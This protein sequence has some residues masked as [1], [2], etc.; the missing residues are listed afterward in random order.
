MCDHD[1]ENEEYELKEHDCGLESHIEDIHDPV[2]LLVGP[3]DGQWT[4]G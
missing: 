4:L 2:E 3:E 1:E